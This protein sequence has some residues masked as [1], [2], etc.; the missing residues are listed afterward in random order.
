VTQIEPDIAE[1]PRRDRV[2]PAPRRH[3]RARQFGAGATRRLRM[4]RL[5]T[6]RENACTRCSSGRKRTAERAM[7]RARSQIHNTAS[8]NTRLFLPLR[9]G[10]LGLPRQSGSIFARLASVKTIVPS[11][12]E[13]QPLNP[14]RP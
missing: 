14:N 2:G 1:G 8:T 6:G 13:S 12:L 3:W 7:D 11:E 5:Q 4:D 9:T 10:S